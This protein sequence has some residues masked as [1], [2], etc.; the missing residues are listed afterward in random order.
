MNNSKEFC[1]KGEQRNSTNQRVILVP[2]V[3]WEPLRQIELHLLSIPDIPS[4]GK[5]STSV[6]LRA[7]LH[8][9]HSL[10][11]WGRG[12]PLI[13]KH[14]SRQRC[15]GNQQPALWGTSLDWPCLMMSMVQN[16]PSHAGWFQAASMK[17]LTAESGRDAHKP[18][19][20]N[21]STP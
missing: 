6:T 9:L 7:F 4:M 5:E 19:G 3:L 2:T 21:S 16:L 13:R 12:R 10:V 11:C 17:S 18:M 8:P 14:G 20:A 1:C 15:A